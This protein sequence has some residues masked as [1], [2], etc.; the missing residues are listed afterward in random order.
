[1][2]EKTQQIFNHDH[3]RNGNVASGYE[4]LLLL[5]RRF[6]YI[7]FLSDLI[8]R[9]GC[10]VPDQSLILAKVMDHVQ[11]TRHLLQHLERPK[12]QPMQLEDLAGAVHAKGAALDNCWRFVDGTVC[13][14][15][16]LGEPSNQCTQGT[17]VSML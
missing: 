10:S 4:G 14:I 1:M 11:E 13:L 3:K 5:L 9:F 16:H 15:F 2:L 8:G 12:L 17:N 6:D 7:Y